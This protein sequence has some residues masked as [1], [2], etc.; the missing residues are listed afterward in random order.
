MRQT[1]LEKPVLYG[2][3]RRQASA[4]KT[5]ISQSRDI[6]VDGTHDPV[7]IEYHLAENG[8]YRDWTALLP[9]YWSCNVQE[10]RLAYLKATRPEL[11]R[12]PRVRK[13]RQPQLRGEDGKFVKIDKEKEVIK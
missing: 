7:A 9:G 1:E 2:E 12:K 13:A 11:F 5:L 6:W 3:W 4:R 8:S 10:K